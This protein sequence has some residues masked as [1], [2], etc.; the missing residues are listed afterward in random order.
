M[1]SV[2]CYKWLSTGP[3]EMVNETHCQ[4][5]TGLWIYPNKSCLSCTMMTYENTS[6]S[7]LIFT[8]TKTYENVTW[9]ITPVYMYIHVYTCRCFPTAS[10]HFAPW[11]MF[12][13]T[14]TLSILYSIMICCI[15]CVIAFAFYIHV[16]IRYLITA[17]TSRLRETYGSE[18]SESP[19][20]LNGEDSEQIYSK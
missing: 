16:L 2:T 13:E 4:C 8:A 20:S 11:K 15:T 18:R 5:S 1:F 17:M 3:Q 14:L 12:M 6:T 19:W 10:R 9:F 7:L